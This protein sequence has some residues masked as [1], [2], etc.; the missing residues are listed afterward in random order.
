MFHFFNLFTIACLSLATT[1]S[2]C[3]DAP[4]TIREITAVPQPGLSAFLKNNRAAIGNKEGWNIV[5][6]QNNTIIK[7]ITPGINR[8]ITNKKRNLIASESG[9]TCFL[10]DTK[11]NGPLWQH[12]IDF[13]ARCTFTA[14]DTLWVLNDNGTLFNN[15]GKEYP[16]KNAQYTS[17]RLCSH[18]TKKQIF[19]ILEVYTEKDGLTKDTLYI[20]NLEG[21][22]PSVT[23]IP[24]PFRQFYNTFS[25]QALPAEHS[26]LGSII[27]LYY[28]C[29]NCWSLYNYEN[30]ETFGDSDLIGCLNLAFHPTKPIIAMIMK[31]NLLK[32]YNFQTQ[33]F[34][35]QSSIP[36]EPSLMCGIIQRTIDFSPDGKKLIFTPKNKCFVADI[37]PALYD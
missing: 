20:A 36:E 28:P 26:P 24:L 25:N 21:H 15:Q 13:L 27:A 3:M 7:S 29:D 12:N 11:N 18:P 9:E 34:V 37:N 6:I 30:K 23:S 14:D 31:N 10:Y 22:T 4:I 32:L 1:S 17:S 5:D 33:K 35:A 2:T 8:I 16:L 19:Y